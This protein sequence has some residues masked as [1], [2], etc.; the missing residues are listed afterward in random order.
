MITRRAIFGIIAAVPA[1]VVAAFKVPQIVPG[2]AI[3]YG[4][5]GIGHV[6]RISVGEPL[7]ARQYT[8]DEVCRLLR[9]PRHLIHHDIVMYGNSTIRVPRPI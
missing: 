1:A 5:G 3:V 9:V 4:G 2:R 8:A 6:A 7:E